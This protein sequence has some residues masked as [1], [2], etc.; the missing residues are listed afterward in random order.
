MRQVYLPLRAG[1]AIFGGMQ[2]SV[3][4]LRA[5]SATLKDETRLTESLRL[6]YGFSLDSVTFLD[7]LNYAS[8]Y[9]RL[10]YELG[11]NQALQFSYAS[12]VPPAELFAHDRE[13]AG[14]IQGDLAGLALF[15]RISLRSGHVRLQR[16]QSWEAGYRRV[17]GSRTV[18]AALY[19]EAVS[20]A[21]VTIAGAQSLGSSEDLLPDVF[22]ES[23]IFNAGRYHTLG[24]IASL[25][26]KFGDHLDAAVAFASGGA[27]T[28][29]DTASEAGSPDELRALIR[30]GH[31]HSITARASGLSPWTGTQF[32]ASYQW[33]DLASV[34]PSHMYL[35]QSMQ[36]AAGLNL[37]VRQP[38][39]YFGGLPG[40]L[41][42]T[43]DLRNLLAQ[44]YVPV[45][46][47]GGR[48]FLVPYPRSLRGGLSF[49]F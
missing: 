5:L 13:G 14:Q 18:S 32:R 9:G 44:G 37:Q 31:R 38:I 4:V 27:L 45:S 42:A 16:S 1:A 49:I 36:E 40:R 35:T 3:P 11:K 47:A 34:T 25:A 12:G 30:R 26:Q 28:V 41:E 19:S 8:P 6:E 21:A 39:P 22:S 2:E 46:A 33:A 24:Y 17:M 23:W 20:N 15:P 48:M 43:A 7:R 29:N 10:T